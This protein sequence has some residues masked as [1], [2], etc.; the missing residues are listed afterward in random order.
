[1]RPKGKTRLILLVPLVLLVGVAAL[2]WWGQFERQSQSHFY[3]GTIEVRQANLAFQ[4]PG[5]VT[6]VLVDEGQ[7]I[8]TDQLLAR[9]DPAVFEAAVAQADAAVTQSRANL[10]VLK[11]AL[12]LKQVVL[13]V[14]IKRAE[15]VV[16]GL[17][18][19][20]RELSDGYRPQEIAKARLNVSDAQSAL[21]KA[22]KDK[23]RADQLF[24]EKLMSASL[25][26][27]QERRYQNAGNQY[28]LALENLNL[29]EE[30]ARKESVAASQARLAEGRAALLLARSN[31]MQIDVAER[32]V[33]VAHARVMAAVAV[34]D[35]ARLQ[36]AYTE[37]KAPFSGILTSR[38]IEP[39]E[40]VSVG[41]EVLSVADLSQVDLKIFVEGTEIGRVKPDQTVSVRIDTYPD[42]RYA[43]RVAYISPESEFTP[44]I[45]QTQKER[46]KLVYL[47]KITLPNPDLDLKPGMPADAWFE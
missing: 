6:E 38:N 34:L 18:Y 41:R 5:R 20:Y 19:Q 37:L 27:T 22:R 29:I 1:M 26:E 33:E 12:S 10:K 7:A 21:E 39:G 23:Q 3:S 45:I 43:G 8:R 47:V 16:R 11:A 36:R 2:V 31:L 40:V 9:L 28:R 4:T 44:K 14:E 32:E 24:K 30:G 35:Q 42:K 13:P 46:V 17:E 15:A 25:R